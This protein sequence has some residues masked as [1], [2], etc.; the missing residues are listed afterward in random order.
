MPGQTQYMDTPV[1]PT[2]AF[3]EGLQPSGLRLSGC[4]AGDQRSRWRRTSDPGWP[5]RPAYLTIKALGDQ[6][7]NNNAY[8]GPSAIG[9]FQSE[10]H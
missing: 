2:S 6:M 1:V 8:S 4:H 9:A 7:V 10:N 5:L 3:A